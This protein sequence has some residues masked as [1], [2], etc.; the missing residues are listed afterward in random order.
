[1]DIQDK[2]GIQE[3]IDRHFT[4]QGVLEVSDRLFAL[5]SV[6][7]I[8]EEVYIRMPL[9]DTDD[10]DI[11]KLLEAIK[12]ITG[13][14]YLKTELSCG[15]F[16]QLK[17][18]L[19]HGTWYLERSPGGYYILPEYRAGHRFPTRLDAEL[20][21]DL[22]LSFDR[23]IPQIYSRADE[24]IRR[25]KEA[26]L[27][28]EIFKSSVMGIISGLVKS[29]RIRIPGQPYVRGIDPRKIHIYFENSPDV[30]TCS[31]EKIEERLI[32]KYGK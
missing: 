22:I 32:K 18:T 26:M 24:E 20:A 10:R 7:A 28:T 31:L 17:L 11:D 9:R 2:Y 27:T 19:Q 23:Y 3:A 13:E 21:A 14:S 15:L 25:R 16:Q 5:K 1:M 30:I 8:W 6:G 4:N 12:A 29:K